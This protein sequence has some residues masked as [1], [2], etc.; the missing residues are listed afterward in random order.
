[1][2]CRGMPQPS[3]VPQPCLASLL[4]GELSRTAAS[5]DV[6]QGVAPKHAIVASALSKML[7][8]SAEAALTSGSLNRKS[9]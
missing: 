9:I 2:G 6:L 8:A 4:F 7:A 3:A 1:M 5:G